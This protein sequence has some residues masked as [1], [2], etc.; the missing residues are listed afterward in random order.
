[1]I[2]T[3]WYESLAVVAFE[4]MANG[5]VVCSTHV[6]I[7]SDLA[8][9]HCLTAEPGNE[10]QLA[11]SILGLIDDSLRYEQLRVNAYKWAKDH[12]S[13][14]YV[15]QLSEIYHQLMSNKRRRVT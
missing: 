1:L 7:M 11:D 12:D 10:Q 8:G 14:Y 15:S 5:V 4:A 6:G 9:T 3:S 2:H 13:N